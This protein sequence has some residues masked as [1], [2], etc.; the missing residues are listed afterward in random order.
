MP[1]DSRKKKRWLDCF[2]KKHWLDY[3][4]VGAT[5]ALAIVAAI[6]TRTGM[7]WTHN[8]N[9]LNQELLKHQQELLQ[10]QVDD[11]VT[12]RK[13]QTKISETQVMASMMPYLTCNHR[14]STTALHVVEYAAPGL[15]LEAANALVA[16][17]KTPQESARVQELRQSAQRQ[18]IQAEFL[19]L[20]SNA[21][22][23][24]QVGSDRD[25][26]EQYVQAYQLLPS[27]YEKL[28][29][30]EAARQAREALVQ[31]HNH[32]AAQ[33]FGI[34]FKNI[35]LGADGSKNSTPR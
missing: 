13:L 31:G 16:C 4:N 27:Q 26:A 32:E 21:A 25:A 9:Q 30:H 14:L 28:V 18:K 15:S 3:L 22:D 12:S 34:A 29:D 2:K 24:L 5:I 7:Q 6:A 33:R 35:D 17:A 8:D 11:Q 23:Y 20:L 1:D 19:S 10:R